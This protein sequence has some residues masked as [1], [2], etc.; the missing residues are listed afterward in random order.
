MRIAGGPHSVT[1]DSV[2][3]TLR[4]RALTLSF[5]TVLPVVRYGETPGYLEFFA[6][7]VAEIRFRKPKSLACDLRR[8]RGFLINPGDECEPFTFGFL[9][10]S[11]GAKHH[12]WVWWS[13]CKT[14]Y[15][16][17]ISEE[18]FLRCH[19]GIVAMLDHAA[20]LGVELDVS[21]EGEFWETRS[22]ERLLQ[23]LRQYNHLM[24]AFAG[25]LTDVLGDD[26]IQAPILEHPEFERIE[27]RPNTSG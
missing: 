2:L 8:A 15:A 27:M 19:T 23:H 9:P 7:G 12:D 10:R 14:Q 17:N 20:T 18:H 22:E 4:D 25:R 24:A 6:E 26:A 21:D 5:E 13:A 1:V 3:N 11:S 16:S